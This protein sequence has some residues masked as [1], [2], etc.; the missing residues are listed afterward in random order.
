M[1][2]AFPMLALADAI[3]GECTEGT[4]SQT[5]AGAFMQGVCKECFYE[6]NCSLK[7]IMSVFANVG[8]YVIGI[9]AS[10]VFLMYVIG[11]IFWIGSHGD[12]AW[13]EKGKKY[14]RNSTIG[15][16]IVLFAYAG[17]QTLKLTLQTG[18]VSTEVA[19]V[20]CDGTELTEDEPC[21]DNSRCTEGICVSLCELNRENKVCWDTSYFPGATECEDGTTLCPSGGE[22]IQCCYP[23]G[24]IG[25]KEEGEIDFEELGR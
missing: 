23:A 25:E 8:N 20:I 14:I 21:G 18:E 10:L 12:K 11:G 19:T 3:T 5:E 7:D 1:F 15:M 4:A 13:V 24:Y 2:A 6:G 9:I 16:L 17:I 22:D